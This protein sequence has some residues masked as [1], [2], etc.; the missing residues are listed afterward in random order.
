M[1][2]DAL[3]EALKLSNTIVDLSIRELERTNTALQRLPDWPLAELSSLA[4][5]PDSCSFDFAN[6]MGR[7]NFAKAYL[8]GILA[9]ERTTKD[10]NYRFECTE[11]LITALNEAHHFFDRAGVTMQIHAAPHMGRINVQRPSEPED[12][13]A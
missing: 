4:A 13:S 10:R 12:A 2:L 5:L 11:N 9:D 8:P 6:G 3:I 7:L 1:E